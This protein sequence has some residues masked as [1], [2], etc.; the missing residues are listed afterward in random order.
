MKLI[1]AAGMTN[2]ILNFEYAGL[3]SEH[4]NSVT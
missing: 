2:M 1:K 4:G 3:K